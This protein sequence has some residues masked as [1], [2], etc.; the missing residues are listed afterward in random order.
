[1][2]RDNLCIIVLIKI[3]HKDA[4]RPKLAICYTFFLSYLFYHK[5]CYLINDIC[6]VIA[7][8]AF[9]GMNMTSK[10]EINL[11]LHEPWLKHDSHGFTFH[12]MVTITIVPWG[13]HK[14]N[15]P[16]CLASVNLWQLLEEPLVLWRVHTYTNHII[17]C[18][19]LSTNINFEISKAPKKPSTCHK[20]SRKTIQ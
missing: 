6:Y 18:S 13:M 4:H 20:P 14:N 7:Y 17:Y 1:M 11:V 9:V 15:Q 16:R 2:I 12:I 19:K 8:R 10:Y 5:V 3:I